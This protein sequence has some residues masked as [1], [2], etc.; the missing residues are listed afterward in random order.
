MITGKGINPFNPRGLGL[1]VEM[2]NV[3]VPGATL[4]AN[5]TVTPN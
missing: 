4:G 2:M 1:E 3:T 5:A